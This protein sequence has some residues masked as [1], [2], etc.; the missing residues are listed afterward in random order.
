MAKVKVM[1]VKSSIGCKKDQIDT[2]KALGLKKI[3]SSRELEDTP[4]IQGMITKVRHLVK[5]EKI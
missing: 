2:L 3:R 5:A 1:Q 4:A